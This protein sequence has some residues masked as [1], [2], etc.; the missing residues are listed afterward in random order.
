M[1]LPT[2]PSPKADDKGSGDKGDDSAEMMKAVAK[3][4]MTAAGDGKIINGPTMALVGEKGPEMVLPLNDMD[5]VRE[6][7]KTVYAIR[8]KGKKNAKN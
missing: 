3:M 4:A 8:K 5:R 1:E 6:I 7:L 2:L